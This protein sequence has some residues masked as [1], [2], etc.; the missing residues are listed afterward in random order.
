MVD[1]RELRQQMRD[2]F[3]DAEYPL[4]NPMELLPVLPDGPA[5]R[6]ESGDFSMSVVELSTELDSEFPYETVD[7]MIDHIIE[8]LETNGFL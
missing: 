4:E 6:F 5:T 1:E 3:G 2:A 7:D 8:E